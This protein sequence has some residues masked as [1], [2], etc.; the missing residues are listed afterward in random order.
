MLLEFGAENFCSF[1][2]G[3]E[4]SFQK[5]KKS[6]EDIA[7]IIAIEGANASGKTNVIKILA[8]L[9]N[10]TTNSFTYLKPDEEIDI[11][12]FFNNQNPITIYAIFLEKNIE[13]KYELVLTRQK[14]ISETIWKKDKRE[15]LIIERD[16]NSIKTTKE[17]SELQT[18]NLN[19]KN[20]SIISIAKQYGI[21]KI[22]TIYNLFDKIITNVHSL[23]KTDNRD[24]FLDVDSVSKVYFESKEL[25]KFVNH[26]LQQSDIGIFNIEIRERKNEETGEIIYFPIFNYQIDEKN[27]YLTYYDQSSGTQSLYL[28]LHLY[29]SVISIGGVLA[30]DEFDINLHPDLLPMLLDFFENQEAN[31]KNA[32][33]IV[34]THNYDI[35]DRL[36]KYKTVLVNKEDNESFLYRLDEIPGDMIRNDR[37]ISPIYNA[38][39]I[40]GKPRIKA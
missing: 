25:L 36:G 22:D 24:M 16:E 37:P 8:F 10:F 9:R 2:E 4:I 3:F 28:Q 33:L 27:N 23:G 15:T 21:E 17:Y 40:G 14:V 11:F 29:L 7:N 12:S 18:I 1:K 39:K 26:F 31:K 6:I 35:M 32:Q 5:S 20:S 34:T 30:L 38:N 13:Y 19:R